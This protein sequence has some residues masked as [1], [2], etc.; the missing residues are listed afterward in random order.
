MPTSHVAKASTT[1]KSLRATIPEEIVTA[2][3]LE[4]GDVLKWDLDRKEGRKVAVIRKL[5]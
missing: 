2:L 5:E 3:S 1:S 4:P